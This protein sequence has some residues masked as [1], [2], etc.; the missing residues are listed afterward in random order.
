MSVGAN[1]VKSDIDQAAR[2]QVIALKDLLREIAD[3]Q[4]F[5]QRQGAPG[6]VTMG[7]SDQ[8]AA[9]L[10]SA[11]NDLASFGQIFLG[12]VAPAGAQPYSYLTFAGLLT[13]I[14]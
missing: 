10:S 1:P 11:Y 13:G 5:I 6:L 9:V 14:Q 2:D 3:L 4:V 7:W 12:N 8:E